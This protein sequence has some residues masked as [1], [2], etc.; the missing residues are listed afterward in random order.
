[1]RI[2]LAAVIP[3]LDPLPF[4]QLPLSQPHPRTPAV[5]GDEL[6]AA[7]TRTDYGEALFGSTSPAAP[8]KQ[9]EVSK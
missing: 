7:V 5:F 3:D 8:K 9:R 1:M 6:H 4:F 2:T